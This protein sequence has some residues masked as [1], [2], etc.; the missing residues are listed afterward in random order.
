[1]VGSLDDHVAWLKNLSIF[2]VF[3]AQDLVH[4]QGHVASLAL[5]LLIAAVV[6]FGIAVAGFRRR[7][8]SL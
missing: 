8:V 5:L 2:T 4:G 6:L 1:M 7:E 3:N